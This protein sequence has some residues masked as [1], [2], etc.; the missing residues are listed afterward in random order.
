MERR[1][2]QRWT[3]R[4]IARSAF[5][6]VIE[7]ESC[8]GCG[9]CIE[10]CQFGALSLQD[11]ACVVEYGRCMGCGLCAAACPAGALHLERLS[12]GEM[13]GLPADRRAWT[14]QRLRGRGV[15]AFT[16]MGSETE[17]LTCEAESRL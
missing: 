5:E 16:R 14:E 13:P 9:E 1:K 7:S 2:R 17:N 6:L 11:Q 4:F 3:K 12:E 8:T 15:A 10:R